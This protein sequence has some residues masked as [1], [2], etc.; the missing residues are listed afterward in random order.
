MDG[1]QREGGKKRSLEAEEDAQH[2]GD[3][4]DHLTVRDVQEELFPYPLA[5]L[6]PALGMT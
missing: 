3:G 4:E 5:P 2:F 6:L 1:S